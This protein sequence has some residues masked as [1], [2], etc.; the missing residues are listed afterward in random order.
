MRYKHIAVLLVLLLAALPLGA[1]VWQVYD[2]F[3]S[4]HINPAL[5]VSKWG[6]CENA[7]DCER[8]TR[9]GWLQLRMRGY[10]LNITDPNDPRLNQQNWAL[11]NLDVA[12]PAGIVGI[13]AT[14]VVTRDSGSPTMGYQLGQFVLRA[15]FFSGVSQPQEN[16]DVEA[17]ISVGGGGGNNQL[18]VGALVNKMGPQLETLGSADLGTVHVG[19]PITIWLRWDK[20]GH[21][22]LYGL[23]RLLPNQTVVK[24]ISYNTSDAFFPPWYPYRSVQ[25]QTSPPNL[26]GSQSFSDWAVTI[27]RVIVLR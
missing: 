19:E 2:N 12:D 26:L 20:A 25:L 27:T 23:Q 3:N 6:V 9:I 10:G 16:R 8:Q 7:L 1:Q 5:W 14:L 18:S 15:T 22:F 4:D 21:R 17:N 13:G 24:E 11:N